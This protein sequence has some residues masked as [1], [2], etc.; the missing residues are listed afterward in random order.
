MT[1]SFRLFCVEGNV[2]PGLPYVIAGRATWLHFRAGGGLE[3][4]GQLL[5]DARYYKSVT[6][7]IATFV[8]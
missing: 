7:T 1:A 3:W 5:A 2:F 6:P 4:G 8:H